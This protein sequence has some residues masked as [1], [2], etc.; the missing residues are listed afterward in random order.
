[1]AAFERALLHE[2]EDV[3]LT[4]TAQHKINSIVMSDEPAET[5]VRHFKYYA[6]HSAF[7]DAALLVFFKKSLKPAIRTKVQ[8]MN[9]RPAT[10]Q[11]WYKEVI[12]FDRQYRE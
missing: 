8:D 6:R 10:L 9:P 3:D 2:F 12:A 11:G 5:H 1:Y 4:E 7:N